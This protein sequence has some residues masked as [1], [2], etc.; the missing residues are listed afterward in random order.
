MVAR[1]RK[2]AVAL[3]PA[4][5]LALGLAAGGPPRGDDGPGGADGAL[6]RLTSQAAVR[7]GAP[8][9]PEPAPVRFDD[10]VASHDRS[11]VLGTIART[12]PE[13][14][15]LLDLVTGVVE[16]GVRP[17]GGPE[18]GRTLRVAGGVRVELDLRDAERLGDRAVRRTVLHELGHAVDRVIVDRRLERAADRAAPDAWPCGVRRLWCVR[19]ERFAETFARWSSGDLDEVEPS[20]PPVPAPPPSW[21]RVLQA[22]R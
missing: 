3:L 14:R 2:A 12:R 22:L 5:L 13:A 7:D 19:A 8:R 15:R 16:V 18:R 17:V 11:A 4:L 21:G 20:A 6:F 10:D 1:P 9:L